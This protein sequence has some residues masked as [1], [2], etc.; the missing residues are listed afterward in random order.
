M[1]DAKRKPSGTVE[2]MKHSEIVRVVDVWRIINAG[3]VKVSFFTNVY[4]KDKLVN[5]IDL[6]LIN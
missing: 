5:K 4:V 6:V 2:S 1:I 3:F